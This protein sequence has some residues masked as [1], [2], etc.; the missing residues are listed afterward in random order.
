[1][2]HRAGDLDRLPVF[3]IVPGGT[4][5]A[6]KRVVCVRFWRMGQGIR[7]AGMVVWV[8][9]CKKWENSLS[10]V[11]VEVCASSCVPFMNGISVWSRYLLR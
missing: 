4:A 1:M 8:N 6:I 7:I 2:N 5:M 9:V 3:C 11:D 10:W